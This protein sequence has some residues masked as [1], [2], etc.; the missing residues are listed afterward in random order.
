MQLHGTAHHHPNSRIYQDL[1]FRS[2]LHSNIC[3]ISLCLV[4]NALFR[5]TR[6]YSSQRKFQTSHLIHYAY[7]YQQEA[8][9]YFSGHPPL[10]AL[11]LDPNNVGLLQL[12]NQ[13]K[14]LLLFRLF[15]IQTIHLFDS[16]IPLPRIRLWSCIGV[17][18]RSRLIDSP[19]IVLLGRVLLLFHVWV[20]G[21]NSVCNNQQKTA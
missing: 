1:V 11:R 2:L 5:L 21:R 9:I 10:I 17:C 16:S 3:S 6:F 19:P 4:G 14:R 12:F 8:Q 13:I 20:H 18:L 15:R 7:F